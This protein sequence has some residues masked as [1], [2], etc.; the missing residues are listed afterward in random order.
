MYFYGASLTHL[1]QGLA[2]GS[3]ATG[4]TL[5]LLNTKFEHCFY[6]VCKPTYIYSQ[7]R[8]PA[9]FITTTT[10]TT[11]TTTNNNNNTKS[12]DALDLFTE[13]SSTNLAVLLL[14]FY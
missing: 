5:T 3:T 11:T 6:L 2:T 13:L 14:L 10:T 4:V 12:H 1:G 9:V 8:P 7:M